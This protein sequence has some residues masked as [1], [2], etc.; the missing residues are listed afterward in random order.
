MYYVLKT[1]TSGTARGTGQ[2]GRV[3]STAVTCFTTNIIRRHSRHYG[4]TRRLKVEGKIRN[5][6]KRKLKIPRW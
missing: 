4:E 2:D 6:K 5:V 3:A 1:F